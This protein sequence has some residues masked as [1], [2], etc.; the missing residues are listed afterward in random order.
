MLACIGT[1]FAAT[2]V[3]WPLVLLPGSHYRATARLLIACTVRIADV[4]YW[5]AA[6]ALGTRHLVIWTCFSPLLSAKLCHPN[7]CLFGHSTTPSLRNRAGRRKLASLSLPH[8]SRGPLSVTGDSLDIPACTT[9]TPLA[10]P[11]L[12]NASLRREQPPRNQLPFA[13]QQTVSPSRHHRCRRIF[14]YEPSLSCLLSFGHKR[15]RKAVCRHSNTNIAS[16]V[17]YIRTV[18]IFS[19]LFVT[20]LASL[21]RAAVSQRWG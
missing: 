13:Q 2:H 7:S 17:V 4:R 9:A 14:P 3:I 11:N 18:R 19:S 5:L 1:V 10:V 8:R 20:C 16:Q 15:C 6:R 21:D 12:I